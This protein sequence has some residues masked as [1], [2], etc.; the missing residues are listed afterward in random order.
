MSDT[1]AQKGNEG[2]NTAVVIAPKPEGYQMGL[3]STD[4]FVTTPSIAKSFG[5]AAV[6]DK[7]GAV[8][9]FANKHMKRRE[10]AAA[11]NLTMGKA[12]REKIDALIEK[13]EIDFAEQVKAWLV[14]QPKGS[15]GV[16]RYAYRNTKGVDTYTIAFRGI[17]DRE[18]AM[19]EKMA[20][21]WGC[22]VEEVLKR[23]GAKT[24][25]VEVEATVTQT[26]AQPQP[27]GKGHGVRA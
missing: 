24:S 12:D 7:N 23:M 15:I 27:K 20:D 22:T 11:N 25:A 16:K 19:L 13:S 21:S 4:K 2:S 10:I 18:M 8:V 3:F 14:L 17:P 5:I 9:G 1:T 6:R 26:T